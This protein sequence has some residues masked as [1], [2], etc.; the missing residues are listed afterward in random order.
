M[1]KQSLRERVALQNKITGYDQLTPEQTR[2]SAQKFLA[3]V[4]NFQQR[5]A[6]SMDN[7][8]DLYDIYLQVRK[9]Y[10]RGK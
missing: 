8:I 6:K 4:Q 9:G 3:S 10:H 7:S 1:K 2:E 5:S